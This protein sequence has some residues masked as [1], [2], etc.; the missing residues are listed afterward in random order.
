[1]VVKG[2]TPYQFGRCLVDSQPHPREPSGKKW[3]EAVV[4]EL[5]PKLARKYDCD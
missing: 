5:Y 1:M 3:D 2:I 4:A